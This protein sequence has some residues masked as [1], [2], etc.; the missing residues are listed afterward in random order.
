MIG[1]SEKYPSLHDIE[2]CMVLLITVCEGKGT[3]DDPAREVTY[4]CRPDDNGEYEM[5]GELYEPDQVR[6]L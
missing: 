1:P 2:K 3:P 5:I 4:V 6:P